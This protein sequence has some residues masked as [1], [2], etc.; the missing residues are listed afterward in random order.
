MLGIYPPLIQHALTWRGLYRARAFAQRELIDSGTFNNRAKG[1]RN[2]GTGDSDLV[3][4]HGVGA[5]RPLA[6]SRHVRAGRA[7]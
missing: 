7:R 1:P 2:V 5:L 4:L 6:F 3:Y